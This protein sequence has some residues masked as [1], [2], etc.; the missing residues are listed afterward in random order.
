[1]LEWHCGV[2]AAVKHERRRHDAREKVEDIEIATRS[3]HPGS[4][5][6]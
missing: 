5:F 1:L 6:G 3:L 4:I 2:I